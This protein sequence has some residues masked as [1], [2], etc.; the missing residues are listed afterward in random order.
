M[1]GKQ[2]GRYIDRNTNIQRER[3]RERERQTDIQIE[4]FK[5]D[6]YF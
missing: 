2:T 1:K 3:E 5:D 4:F 6:D